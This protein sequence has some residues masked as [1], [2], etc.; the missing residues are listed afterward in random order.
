MPYIKMWFFFNK[1][2][3]FNDKCVNLTNNYENIALKICHALKH[4]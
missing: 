4:L 2:I 1:F 3:I